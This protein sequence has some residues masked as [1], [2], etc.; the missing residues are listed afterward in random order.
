MTSHW[1]VS[2]RSTNY[3]KNSLADA[4]NSTTFL[5]VE[6]QFI[7]EA[8][9]FLEDAVQLDSIFLNLLQT[10]DRHPSNE[11]FTARAAN[12]LNAQTS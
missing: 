5:G 11:K 6:L 10:L 9:E 8:F 12:A 4:K 2:A 7:G 1:N 3:S